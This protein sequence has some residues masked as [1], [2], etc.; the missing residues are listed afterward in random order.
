MPAFWHKLP[1]MMTPQDILDFWFRDIDAALWWRKDDAF[2]ALLRE[3]FG[4]CHAAAARGELWRWRDTPPGRLA[5]VI[6]LDQFSRNIHRDTPGAFAQD[7]MALV[8]AQELIAGGGDRSLAARERGVLYLPFMHSESLAMQ[9][10]S[11]RLYSEPA[12]AGQ[13]DFAIRHRD[14][15]ARFG[16][17][18]HRNAIL[19][20]VSADEELAFLAQPGSSF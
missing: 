7:G 2:D 6:V 19:G 12:L 9:D 13:L 4:A 10:E 16:R 15:I 5:E 11:V 20:R 17:F 14:I 8:L 1:A 18:P 3:R